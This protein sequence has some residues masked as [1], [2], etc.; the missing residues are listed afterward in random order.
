M[1]VIGL[2]VENFQRIKAVNL[3]PEGNVIKITGGNGAGK[4]SVL[5]AIM[6]ALAGARGGPTAP[7]RRGAGRGAVRIDLGDIRVTRMWAE[8]GDPKG[9]MYIESED[10]K[11]YGTPQRF[12]DSLMGEISFDPLAFNRME[13]KDQAKQLRNL[14]RLEDALA[15]L[16]QNEKNDY[17]TRREETKRL[18]TLEAQRAAI[19]VPEGLPEQ[20]LDLDRMTA[21]L[22]SV[23]EHNMGIEREH[24]RRQQI[25]NKLTE[26]GNEWKEKQEELNEIMAELASMQRSIDALEI[27]QKAIKQAIEAFEPMPEPKDAAVLSEQIAHGRITN[28]ALDRK[29]QAERMD[30]EIDAIHKTV[31]KLDFAIKKYRD[32]AKRMTTEA[33]YPVEGLG[34]SEDGEVMYNGLPFA[35]ASNGEQIKVSVAMGMALN[36]KIRIMRIKD[37]S[38]LDSSSLVAI[39]EMAK[40]N[41]FQVWMELVDESG[42]V[43]VYLVDGEVA[44]IDGQQ[45]EPL[46]LKKPLG[47]PRKKPVKK[48]TV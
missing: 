26:L 27:A 31:G 23:A 6:L 11:R 12:L 30:T 46:Q 14:L 48:E 17:L 20:K 19:H 45:R 2:S 13:A 3:K 33:K 37:G 44:S 15:E 4:T 38:L 34:F 5:D 18:A 25:N 43:G 39:E 21:E 47:P 28:S 22:A 42:K 16:S 35:Q 10:G 24:L 9:E 41:D 36:P 1:K 7:V 8:D 40:S 32:E 29:A